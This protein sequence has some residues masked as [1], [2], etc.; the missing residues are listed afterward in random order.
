MFF[1]FPREKLFSESEIEKYFM[2]NAGDEEPTQTEEC[3]F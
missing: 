1:E 3:P 2:S